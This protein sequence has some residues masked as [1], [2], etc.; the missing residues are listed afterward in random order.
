MN[1]K[2]A[3]Q[4]LFLADMTLGKPGLLKS[5]WRGQHQQR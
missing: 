3:Q 1:S 4:P 5:S 2:G